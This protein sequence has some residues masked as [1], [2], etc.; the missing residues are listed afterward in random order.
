MAEPILEGTAVRQS[1]WMRQEIARPMCAGH[2][3][4]LEG[5]QCWGGKRRHNAYVR[6]ILR[7]MHADWNWNAGWRVSAH[8]ESKL[9]TERH[10]QNLMVLKH[11]SIEGVKATS[12]PGR[13]AIEYALW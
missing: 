3:E 4:A 12:D 1:R 9:A 11:R 13:D 5:M 8:I 6:Y 10:R 2:C 7:A